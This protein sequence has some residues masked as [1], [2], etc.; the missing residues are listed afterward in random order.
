MQR[1]FWMQVVPSMMTCWNI[2]L[3]C[4]RLLVLLINPCNSPMREWRLCQGALKAALVRTSA[5]PTHLTGSTQPPQAPGW[6]PFPRQ[7]NPAGAAGARIILP[8]PAVGPPVS[9][10]LWLPAAAEACGPVASNTSSGSFCQGSLTHPS[11]RRHFSGRALKAGLP[12]AV[13]SRGSLDTFEAGLSG[14]GPTSLALGPV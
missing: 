11:P 8:L 6:A 7:L 9:G 2:S 4:V 13:P 10:V 1:P 14:A 3:T 5:L 12:C